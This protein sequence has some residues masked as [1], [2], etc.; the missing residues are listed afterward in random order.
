[1]YS[2]L[3][4]D[5]LRH[6]ALLQN[7]LANV[8]PD[9]KLLE[10]P[11]PKERLR[12]V[13]EKVDKTVCD[14]VPPSASDLDALDFAMGK[15]RESYEVYK[16]AA[17]SSAD[18]AAKAVFGRMAKEEEQHFEILENTRYILKEYENWSIWEEGGPIEGG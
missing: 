2:Q 14:R 13:F 8:P 5:E 1:M 7:M 3:A 4:E 9:R 16:G 15:E 12:S 11:L 6:K 17:D 18:P 10:I